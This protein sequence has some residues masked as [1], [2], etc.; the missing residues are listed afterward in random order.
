MSHAKGAKPRRMQRSLPFPL[1][2][3]R[4][5]PCELSVQGGDNISREEHEV[6]KDVFPPHNWNPSR[7]P[8]DFSVQG[9][10]NVSRETA[11]ERGVSGDRTAKKATHPRARISVVAR[12]RFELLSQGPEPCMIDR[13]TTGLF[14]SKMLF[15]GPN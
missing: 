5:L 4:V 1:R 2:A 12:S 6:A 7:L 15:V 10:N 8:R 3:S 11:K 14:G 9:E 13:Y